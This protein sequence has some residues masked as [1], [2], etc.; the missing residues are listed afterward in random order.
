[1]GF[2]SEQFKNSAAAS[3]RNPPEPAEKTDKALSRTVDQLDSQTGQFQQPH[4]NPEVS[5]FCQ[6]RLTHTQELQLFFIFLSFK[7]NGPLQ[8][9]KL[10]SAGSSEFYFLIACVETQ[11]PKSTFSVSTQLKTLLRT[12]R[13]FSCSFY[14]NTPFKH[15]SCIF[16]SFLSAYSE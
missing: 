11:E 7:K 16:F 9:L 3:V 6:V 10:L 1:M 14:F 12:F 8:E 15:P 2:G 5:W 13:T 4:I